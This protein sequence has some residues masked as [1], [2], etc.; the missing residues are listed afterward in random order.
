MWRRLSIALSRFL[1]FAAVAILS[2]GAVLRWLD[3]VGFPSENVA[4]C[5]GAVPPLPAVPP[6]G[7]FSLLAIGDFGTGGESLRNREVAHSLRRYLEERDPRPDAALLLG[8][9]FYESGLIGADT[10]CMPWD[11]PPGDGALRAQLEE[12]VRPFEF[13]RGRTIT[14][15]IPGNHD[16]E[17]T[18]FGSLENQARIDRWLPPEARWGERWRLAAG[19]PRAVVQTPLVQVVT[20]DSERMIEDGHFLESSAA[21]LDELLASGGA[22]WRLVAGHH[23]LYA[24]GHHDGAWWTGSL[25]KALYYPSHLLIVPPFLYGNEGNY[26]WKYRRY[27]KRLEAVFARRRVH[28]FLAGHEHALELLRPAS[29]GQPHTLISGSAAR[30][31]GVRSRAN[32]MFAASKNGFA[33]LAGDADRL[34]LEFLGTTP[35]DRAEPCARPTA[36]GLAHLLFR[37]SFGPQ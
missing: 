12:V 20:I 5:A 13:L 10:R 15:A 37:H 26:E 16:Y 23:P 11:D 6:A 31:E 18:R 22:R 8:D 24:N 28:V 35:C 36:G 30:C 1:A 27:V 14:Y 19:E 25:I 34:T 3:E 32:T 7:G 9:N 29:A 17:C 4:G 2:S 21:R 33:V